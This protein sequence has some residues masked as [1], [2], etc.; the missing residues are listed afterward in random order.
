MLKHD[1]LQPPFD[2]G[3]KVN[4]LRRL[5]LDGNNLLLNP[6]FETPGTG[7]TDIWANW[8]EFASDGALA[9]ETTTVHKGNDAAKL[10][11]GSTFGTTITQSGIT[12]VASKIHGF[13]FWTRGDGVNGGSYRIY[14]NSN[15]ADIVS[16][17]AAGIVG[18]TYTK[19]VKEFTT[20]V[21]CTSI[22]VRFYGPAVD[23][24]VSYYDTCGLWQLN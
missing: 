4:F 18:E 17:T 20:P 6:G 23:G 21:G 9:N 11:Q 5:Y 16:V 10:T 1:I 3:F 24:A 12:V 19:A 2:E 22:W 8:S 15:G 7:G 14:D 13:H